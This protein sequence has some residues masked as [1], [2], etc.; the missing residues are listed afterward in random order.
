M[1]Y[2]G[3]SESGETAIGVAK[4]LD[5]SNWVREQAELSFAFE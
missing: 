2:T 3:E 5:L 1:Y 4:T